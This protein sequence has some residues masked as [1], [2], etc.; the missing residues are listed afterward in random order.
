MI[1]LDVA[2]FCYR[3]ERVNNDH[4]YVLKNIFY[5]KNETAIDTTPFRKRCMANPSDVDELRWYME[6]SC[7][8][9]NCKRFLLL[10]Q[11][12]HSEFLCRIAN[13]TGN[14]DSYTG[15]LEII[16]EEQEKKYW[17]KTGGSQQQFMANSEPAFFVDALFF[18]YRD[19]RPQEST[20]CSMSCFPSKIISVPSVLNNRSLRIFLYTWN[21]VVIRDAKKSNLITVQALN[22]EVWI[23]KL[24]KLDREGRAHRIVCYAAQ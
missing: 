4:S 7:L 12:D 22:R 11:N 16:H 14:G 24:Y 15:Q 17:L 2:I 3:W 5:S 20:L 9:I 6:I 13:H 8:D 21:N 23:Y 10:L 19:C 1:Q 18:H